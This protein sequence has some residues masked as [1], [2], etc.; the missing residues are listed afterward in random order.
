VKEETKD[1]SAPT[2]SNV[3]LSQGA[4]VTTQGNR[5]GIVGGV[6]TGGTGDVSIHENRD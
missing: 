3:A 1:T 5:T 6:D 2:T 4:N